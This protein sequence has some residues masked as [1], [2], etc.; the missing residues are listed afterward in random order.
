MNKHTLMFVSILFAFLSG[1]AFVQYAVTEEIKITE[2]IMS[3][4]SITTTVIAWNGVNTWKN[5]IK[6]QHHYDLILEIKRNV[7][8]V[9]IQSTHIRGYLSQI[10]FNILKREDGLGFI[11][12]EI[13]T[14]EVALH[15]LCNQVENC[16]E[17]G[18]MKI[19]NHKDIRNAASTY[20][21]AAQNF[22]D[23]F[24]T[25]DE[26]QVREI[27]T[28][29]DRLIAMLNHVRQELYSNAIH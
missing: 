6:T 11:K 29:T 8:S 19:T 7:D 25:S 23:G 10:E 4:A 17:I 22:V 12:D 24:I 15:E 13:G 14:L 27:N 20:L 28:R 26:I 16:N 9:K 2:I 21:I 5:Q 3:I 1:A 18:L